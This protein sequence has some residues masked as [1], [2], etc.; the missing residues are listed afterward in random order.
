MSTRDQI[1]PGYVS[2]T[3]VLAP[4]SKLHLI[5]PIVL[6]NAADRGTRVHKWCT[7]YVLNLLFG[8]VDLDCRIYV[9]A[10]KRWCDKYVD[11]VLLE[12]TRLNCDQY[13][14]SGE[15]DL[16]VQLKGSTNRVLIDIK[17]PQQASKSWQLQTAAYQIL[18]EKVLC[19]EVD[20]RMILQLPKFEGDAKVIMHD[21]DSK[22][23]KDLFFDALRLHRYYNG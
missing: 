19:E 16:F 10:F 13:R 12:P 4:F 1:P 14:L 7:M 15:F 18:M 21:Q 2:V 8:E 9:E 17:T 20:Q 5:D 22:N 3:E 23:D 11:K 6:Q